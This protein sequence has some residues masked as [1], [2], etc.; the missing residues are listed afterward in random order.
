MDRPIHNTH[1][2]RAASQKTILLSV[3]LQCFIIEKVLGLDN[4]TI[5][6]NDKCDFSDLD[7]AVLYL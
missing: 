6:N 1:C 7:L 2:F 5:Q 4:M 3:M